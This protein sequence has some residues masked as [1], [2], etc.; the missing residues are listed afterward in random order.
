MTEVVEAMMI[1]NLTKMFL[2]LTFLSQR[3]ML[4]I[5]KYIQEPCINGIRNSYNGLVT[6]SWISK[7]KRFKTSAWKLHSLGVN[8][9]KKMMRKMNGKHISLNI[10][11]WFSSSICTKSDTIPTSNRISNIM[12]IIGMIKYRSWTLT[13]ASSFGNSTAM[14]I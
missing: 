10:G 14:E 3:I 4:Q 12:N 8:S 11:A 1:Q 7:T 9:V 2:P 5:S 13:P 6:Q